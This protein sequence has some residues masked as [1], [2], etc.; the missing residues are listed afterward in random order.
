MKSS[1]NFLPSFHFQGNHPSIFKENVHTHEEVPKSL[2]V[3]LQTI[4]IHQVGLPF[5]IH[6]IHDHDHSI[7][8]EVSP[9][10]TVKRITN[11]L[12]LAISV[13]S[14]YLLCVLQHDKKHLHH[15]NLLH[16][17]DP[18]KLPSL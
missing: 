1:H 12:R 3:P 9:N 13:L 10:R 11:G 16:D 4:E 17:L 7:R 5:P 8:R 2:I 18:D 15:Q 14:S 6:R